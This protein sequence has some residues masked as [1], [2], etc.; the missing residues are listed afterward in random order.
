LRKNWAQTSGG[1]YV[2]IDKVSIC[3]GELPVDEVAGQDTVL[4]QTLEVGPSRKAVG[5][6]DAGG[7]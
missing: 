4:D 3:N 7:E 6:E 5:K 1:G 2:T